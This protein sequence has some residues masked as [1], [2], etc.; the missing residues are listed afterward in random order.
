MHCSVTLYCALI[1]SLFDIK[2]YEEQSLSFGIDFPAG[3]SQSMWNDL[4]GANNLGMASTDEV[5]D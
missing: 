3:D 5:L 2:I 4:F 1:L